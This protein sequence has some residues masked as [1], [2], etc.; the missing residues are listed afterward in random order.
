MSA[1]RRSSVICRQIKRQ[2]HEKILECA[3]KTNST[4][5][6]GLDMVAGKKTHGYTSKRYWLDSDMFWSW[7]EKRSGHSLRKQDVYLAS[8]IHTGILLYGN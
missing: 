2:C 8:S 7:R 6:M 4:K 3:K 1:P 5:H